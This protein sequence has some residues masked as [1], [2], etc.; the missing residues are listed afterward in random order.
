MQ[1]YTAPQQAGYAGQLVA[2]RMDV[3]R[4]RKVNT[5]KGPWRLLDALATTRQDPEIEFEVDIAGSRS[6]AV[7]AAGGL[8]SAAAAADVPAEAAAAG[9]SAA[10]GMHLEDVRRIVRDV[11]ADIVGADAIEG[12]DAALEL[13]F[14]CV[15]TCMASCQLVVEN[16]CHVCALQILFAESISRVPKPGV[17]T[18]SGVSMQARRAALRQAASTRCRRWSCPMA[19]ARLWAWSCPAPLPSTTQLW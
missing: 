19:S 11:A 5:A 2:A 12:V 10:A 1:A 15:S 16:K 18:P 9:S 8:P 13:G 6:A 17:D 4:F 7:A 3:G 14:L